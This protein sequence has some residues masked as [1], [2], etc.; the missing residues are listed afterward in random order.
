MKI[1]KLMA[2]YP[3]E[4]V[5]SANMEKELENAMV[6]EKIDLTVLTPYPTRGCDK[7][8]RRA[9]CG[10]EMLY[11][12]H[13]VIKRFPLMRESKN[14]LLRAVRYLLGN[15][16]QYFYAIKETNVDIV[17]A[18]T[19]P[20]TQ[21][22][23]ARIVA[24]K[25]KVPYVLR[26]QDIFPDSMVAAG[27]TKKGSLLWKFGNAL[28]KKAYLNAAQ[29][30]V[31]GEEMCDTLC[32]KDVPREKISIVPNWINAEEIQHVSRENNKLMR[33]LGLPEDKFYVVYA[34]NL[35]KVQ[36]VSTLVKAAAKL[37]EHD[38]I[39]FLIFGEGVEK[40]DIVELSQKMELK[41][42]FFYPLQKKER[43]SEVY[44]IGDI[45]VIMCQRGTGKTAVP[46]KTWSIL[47]TATPVLAAFD[48]DSGLCKT[49][50]NV[51]C[52]ICVRPE[53]ENE[54]ADAIYKA[55]LE[56]DEL[57][58]LGKNG[59]AYVEK[60]IDSSVCIDAYIKVL[61]QIRGKQ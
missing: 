31:I 22:V 32:E 59:R 33:D 58:E 15:F 52:G 35:G 41:T 18:G 25:L 17:L 37:K 30:M 27:M 44:S 54:L 48:S 42:L 57:G 10:T 26:I 13:V 49:I 55:Y 9:H 43:I 23:L 7:N 39:Y 36:N 47:S 1:L 20:P 28:T 16:I 11:D 5:P 34:G 4:N 3:P 21:I 24:K 46:S 6:A 60:T 45:S 2:Y 50:T 51:N 56:K 61:K 12:G 14:S 53:D 40:N 29:T 19:T 38:D 8:T